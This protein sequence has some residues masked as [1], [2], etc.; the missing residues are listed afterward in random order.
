MNWKLEIGYSAKHGEQWSTSRGVQFTQ[1]RANQC[2]LQGHHLK[3]VQKKLEKQQL[4]LTRLAAAAR[5]FLS[6]GRAKCT[7][8]LSAQ[9]WHMGAAAYHKTTA[10]G[11][12][13]GN[14]SSSQYKQGASEW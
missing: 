12:A 4:A 8:K 13:K 9:R 6:S 3:Q 2:T 7:R 10:W 14:R 11:L 5:A 1:G